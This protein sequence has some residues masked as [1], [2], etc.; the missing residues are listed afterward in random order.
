MAQINA[1]PGLTSPL[2]PPKQLGVGQPQQRGAN[3]KTMSGAADQQVPGGPKE[4]Q[5]QQRAASGQA[6]VQGQ[7]KFNTTPVQTT[8]PIPAPPVQAT[9]APP[10]P[11]TPASNQPPNRTGQMVPP[12]PTQ[13]QATPPALGQPVIPG[14]QMIEARASAR[15]SQDVMKPLLKGAHVMVLTPQRR[16]EIL[17]LIKGAALMHHKRANKDCGGPGGP[18]ELAPDQPA[19]IPVKKAPTKIDAIKKTME[20]SPEKAASQRVFQG[21]YAYLAGCRDGYVAEVQPR[22]EVMLKL[23]LALKVDVDQL[24]DAYWEKMAMPWLPLLAGG[25]A[26]MAAPS[27][28]PAAVEGVKTLGNAM[29]H[30]IDTL[31]NGLGGK[32][33]V[34]MSRVGG[35]DPKTQSMMNQMMLEQGAAVRQQRANMQGM[36]EAFNPGSTTSA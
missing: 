7:P 29:L 17:G 6:M 13:G 12:A 36:N 22:Q 1:A 15:S 35:L 2:A 8:Q 18:M 3:P 27:I 10:P 24:Y 32:P 28:I 25:A 19:K 14:Q 4:M 11:Q 34:N 21:S 23:A 9:N 20:N 30:P 5:E 31:A 16:S 26:A 33:P